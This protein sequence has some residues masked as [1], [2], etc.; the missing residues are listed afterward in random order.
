M[1]A[2]FTTQINEYSNYDANQSKN[3][4]TACNICLT[5]VISSDVNLNIT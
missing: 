1:F 5:F 3:P 2:N 4:T